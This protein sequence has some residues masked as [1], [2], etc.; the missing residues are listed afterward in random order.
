VNARGATKSVDDERWDRGRASASAA[1]V[2]FLNQ[3]VGYMLRRAQLAVFADFGE[4][5]AELGLR[6]AQ[7]GVLSVLDRNPGVTQ[8]RV[9]AALGIRHANFVSIIGSL[10]RRGLVERSSS[11]TDR[12]SKSLTLTMAG[13]RALA[14]ASEMQRLHET[15]IGQLLGPGGR[16]QLVRLLERLVESG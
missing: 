11:R 8:S 15:R 6:P 12:R 1:D 4:A 14:R 2:E 7:F 16:A 5:L 3:S 10:E 13:R 9:C